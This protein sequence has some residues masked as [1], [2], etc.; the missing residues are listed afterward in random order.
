MHELSKI[1]LEKGHDV[2]IFTHGNRT[3]TCN[4][5]GVKIN[6]FSTINVPFIRV[7]HLPRK[8]SKHLKNK[9]FDVYHVHTP[10]LAFFLNK[11]PLVVTAHTTLFGEGKSIEMSLGRN[12]LDNIASFYYREIRFLDKRVYD[13]AQVIIVVNENIKDEL[14]RVYKIKKKKIVTINNGVNTKVFFAMKNKDKIKEAL[15]LSSQD[16]VVLYVGRLEARKNVDLLIKALCLLKTENIVTL[17]IGKG[18]K[19]DALKELSEHLGLGT[20]LKF[21]G[22]VT[23]SNLVRIYNASD[24]FVLPSTYEGM[25]LTILEAMACGV[26]V[27]AAGFSGVENILSN[28]KNGIILPE[29]SAA[30]LAE[31]IMYVH[32][33]VAFWQTLRKKAIETITSKFSL[34]AAVEKTI[35]IY[36]HV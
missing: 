25:P 15:G 34:E 23:D 11:G 16:F 28:N 7:L 26:P 21:V 4:E 35:E 13:K 29:T 6:R 32:N 14:E 24:V 10:D 19:G 27:I 12:I 1:L 31:K 22:N 20:R 5:N 17:I 30:C 36:N 3:E 9:D 2:E 8:I 18:S 33:Q